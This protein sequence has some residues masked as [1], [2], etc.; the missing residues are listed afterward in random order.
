MRLQ[1]SF[2]RKVLLLNE[3]FAPLCFVS[4]RRAIK[5]IINQKVSVLSY[6]ENEPLGIK[7]IPY[8]PSILRMN[9]KVYQR[10]YPSNFDR[11]AVIKRDENT[12][13]YCSKIILPKLVTID[14][15]IPKHQQGQTSYLNCV[16]ACRTCNSIKGNRTPEQ[17]GMK[18]IRQPTIPQFS[19]VI[20]IPDLNKFW[21]EDWEPFIKAG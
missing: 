8:L 2:P 16:V 3:N 15:I 12:C 1:H 19:N 7:E 14:H 10:F 5:L 9:Y 13:Q 20:N 17:A 11:Y 4:E 6:W 18:L 21:H